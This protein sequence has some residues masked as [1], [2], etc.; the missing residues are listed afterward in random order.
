MGAGTGSGAGK[1]R[2][3]VTIQRQL[4]TRDELGQRIGAW[5][6]VLGPIPAEIVVRSAGEGLS[7]N[8]VVANSDLT[9][10]IRRS[11]RDCLNESMRLLWHTNG[12][13]VIYIVGFG[14]DPKRRELVLYCK[15]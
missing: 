14:H 2:E 3:R 9:V 11:S 1:Y 15:S 8:Q 4:D 13:Q 10:T 12:D 6:Y 5:E 7:A